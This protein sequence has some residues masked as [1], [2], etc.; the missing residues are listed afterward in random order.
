MEEMWRRGGG[1]V[2]EMRK[3]GGRD[4]EERWRRCGGEVEARWM[5]FALSLLTWNKD[6]FFSGARR[7]GTVEM[8][9]LLDPLKIPTCELSHVKMTSTDM[10]R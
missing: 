10:S 6:E 1:E 3:R 5:T 7:R 2:E 8:C 9:C 4:V